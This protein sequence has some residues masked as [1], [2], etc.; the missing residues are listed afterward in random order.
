MLF[1]SLAMAICLLAVAPTVV[2]AL[3]QKQSLRDTPPWPP[4]G[5]PDYDP[6]LLEQG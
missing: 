4:G 2:P 5:S 6:P 3:L 1:F